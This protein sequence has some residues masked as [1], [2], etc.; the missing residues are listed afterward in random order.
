MIIVR[1][2]YGL[3]SSG[4]AFRALLAETLH[5]LGYKPSY[6]DP[7][8]WMRP[9]VKHNGF[10][11]WEYVLCYVD[12]VLHISSEPEKTMNGIKAK[13]KLKG[14]KIEPPE[15]Y[16]GATMSKMDNC[17][18][19]ECWAMSSDAYCAALVKNVESAL[20]RKGLRLPGK[21]I[22][23]LKHGYRPELD[24]TNEL[25]V[26]GMQWYQEIVGSL[27]WAIEIGRVD[28]LLETSLMSSYL[29]MPR[30]GHLEQVLHIVGYLKQRKKMKLMFD[31]SVPSVDEKWFQ[32]YE[33]FDFYRDA[34]EAIPPN[35]PEAR[36]LPITISTF[37]DSNLAGNVKDR[38][39]QSGVLIFINKSPIHWYSKRQATVETSTF[40]AE[41]TAMKVG[42]E[43]VE[44]LRYKLLRMFGIPIDGPPNVFCDNE[45]V[46]QNTVI[47]ESTLK[48]KHHS[49]AYHRCREA[50]AAGT[51]R[52]A[53]QGTQKNLADVFT[54]TLS[55][56]RRSFLFERF[57]Y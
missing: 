24:C 44:S 36:G 42:V 43:L 26:D 7:D 14:D 28:I 13:F 10:K 3:K 48:K 16:L 56:E 2:L 45:A 1:T 18:G 49:I 35:M 39:S 40:G 37:V 51:I 38:R 11:Y 29:A 21:C 34:K 9:A 5:D 27:R 23:P 30:E 20:Q 50:V 52:V 19:D 33:W 22:T 54:K 12:D 17:D 4:A 15:M 31:S 55:A 46:Y 6:A 25:K 57:T 47:P 41:F 8:V 32:K 53:K